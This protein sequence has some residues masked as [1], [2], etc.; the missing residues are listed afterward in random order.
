VYDIGE[1]DGLHFLTMEFIDGDDLARLLRRIGRFPHD[2]AVEIA[3]RICSALS[4]AHERGVLHRDLKPVNVMLN[5]AG[6]VVVTDFGLAALAEEVKGVE[7]RSGTPAYMAPEQAMG[8]RV[9][10]R[11]D[12]YSLGLVLYELFTGQPAF[13][14]GDRNA[15][16]NPSSLVKDLDPEVERVILRCLAEDPEDRPATAFAVSVMLPG[17]DPL[18]VALD[19]GQTPP[20]ELVAASGQKAGIAVRSAVCCLVAALAALFCVSDFGAR[21]QVLTRAPIELPPEGLAAK[22]RELAAAIGYPSRPQGRA[23]GFLYD[24]GQIR[25]LD[26]Q[27]WSDR[28]LSWPS[29]VRFWY[30]E[31]PHGLA[32][33]EL[34]GL[35]WNDPPQN[36]PGMISVQLDGSGRLTLFQALPID[37]TPKQPHG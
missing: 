27:G 28:A 6:H 3:R 7:S 4:A 12:I 14:T 18:Q 20:P 17:G 22:A 13:E 9:S 8:G 19:A 21:S 32:S 26:R 2:K 37:T 16:K 15:L 31:S 24:A 33:Y 23:F 25:R 35:A 30:R 1:S 36:V 34:K 10:V 11:S 5:V 29:P